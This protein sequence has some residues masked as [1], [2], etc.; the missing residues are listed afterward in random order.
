[1]LTVE[2]VVTLFAVFSRRWTHKWEKTFVD[3]K[4]RSLWRTDLENLGI[5]DALLRQGLYASCTL[6]WPPS[7]AE[8][9]AMCQPDLGLP[10]AQ[11]AFREACHGRFPHEVVYE[12]VRRLGAWELRHWSDAQGRREFMPV[13]AAVCAEYRQGAR[14]ALPEARQLPHKRRGP[15]QPDRELGLKAIADM[16]VVLGRGGPPG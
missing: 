2:S 11:E 12:A 8:F 4:A 6:S 3:E 13:Y 10:E 15:Y 9:A 7:P 5:S 14:W 1:V 16:W